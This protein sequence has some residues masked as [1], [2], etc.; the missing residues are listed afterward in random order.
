MQGMQIALIH[1]QA[2]VNMVG[3]A[4][5]FPGGRLHDRIGRDVSHEM[6]AEI[7]SEIGE[8]LVAES[9][10]GSHDRGRVHVIVFGQGT[11][12]QKVR[13]FWMV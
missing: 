7:G 2:V 3:D 1:F 9:L 11:R 12:G 13:V 10:D 8:A 6:G 4:A 5:L